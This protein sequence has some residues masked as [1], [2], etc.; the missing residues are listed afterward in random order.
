MDF[1]DRLSGFANRAT[2][3]ATPSTRCV[4]LYDADGHG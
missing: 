3:T 1:A 2:P 4:Y